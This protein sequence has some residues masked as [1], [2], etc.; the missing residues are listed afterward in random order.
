MKASFSPSIS[1]PGFLSS[2]C[3]PYRDRRRQRSRANPISITW[4]IFSLEHQAAGAGESIIIP[5]R[6]RP[7]SCRFL[8]SNSAWL[9]YNGIH[10]PFVSRWIPVEF[11]LGPL[12]AKRREKKEPKVLIAKRTHWNYGFHQQHQLEHDTTLR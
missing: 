7:K 2:T 1:N 11:T 10:R 8:F 3:I 4:S 9:G 5:F 6:A 12:G